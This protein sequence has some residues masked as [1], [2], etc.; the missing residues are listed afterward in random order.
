MSVLI[1]SPQ[2][3]TD[4]APQADASVV[5]VGSGPVG[6][7]VVQELRRHRPRLPIVLCGAETYAPY[8]RVRLSSFLM[9]E[10]GLA[11]LSLDLQLPED[12]AFSPRLGCAIS[13]IDRTSR[14]VIDS[15]GRT[16]PYSQLVL[17]MGSSPHIPHIA[18]VDLPGVFTFRYF[19]DAEKLFARRVRSRRCVVLGGGL[20]GLEAAR[21]M[22]RFQTEVL[23]VEHNARLMPRQLDEPSA[24][25]TQRHIEAMG[26]GVVLGDGVRAL[27]GGSRIEG[28]ELQSGR[29]IPCD[30]VIIA[31]GIRPN[32]ELAR[33]AGLHVGRGIRIDDQTR[34]NDPNIFAVGECA[35]HRDVVYG[36]VAPGFEQASVAAANI[37]GFAAHYRGSIA[38][39]KLKVIG[40]PVFSM[41]RVAEEDVGDRTQRY[42]ADHVPGNHTTLVIE[43][44][45]LVGA[46]AVGGNSE[47]NRLQETVIRRGRIWFWQ[48]WRFR[49]S[50][51]LWAKP[52]NDSVALWP[53]TA[54]VCNCTGVTRGQLS[55]ALGASCNTL[56]SLSAC[57]GAGKVCGSCRPLLQQLLGGAEQLAPVRGATP[58]LA[59]S[60]L[61]ALSVTLL[62]LPW[63]LADTSTVQAASPLSHWW[64]DGLRKQISGYSL[65]ALSAFALLLSLRKRVAGFRW[66]EFAWWR[67]AHLAVGA[68]I[69]FGL[70]LHTG[71][72]LGANLNLLLSASVCGLLVAGSVSGAVIANE[73]RLG[74]RAAR[75]RRASVWTHIL[76]FFPVPVL[77][78]FH[79]LQVYFF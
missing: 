31:T 11:D 37:A 41:G 70:A 57:T 66:G 42:C 38:A 28:V 63:N 25:V 78:G 58:A 2:I 18:G 68:L 22:R 4:A 43:R 49:T 8:D 77:L 33:N 60:L 9:G 1:A 10:L 21:A 64:R 45:R 32:V 79:I 62:M 23:V 16:L 35:E 19:A 36:L 13:S 5:V 76:L 52:H 12:V 3:V 72:R 15:R 30:T 73:H 56:A 74:A 27:L 48:R 69:P 59:L 44:G 7:R 67:V 40:L 55:A 17:A 14:L 29:R 24:R 20:L 51:R 65:L 26:I 46:A 50:G 53:A 54:I 47:I 6:V 75:L 34:T 71:G 39:T 61:A